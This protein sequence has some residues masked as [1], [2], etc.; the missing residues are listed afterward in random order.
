[1]V[2]A[3]VYAHGSTMA[4]PARTDERLLSQPR[5]AAALNWAA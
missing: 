3:D 5:V 4:D 1:V 2:T